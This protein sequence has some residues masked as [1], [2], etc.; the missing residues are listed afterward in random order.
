MSTYFQYILYTAMFSEYKYREYS[1]Y[2][3]YSKYLA[4]R[5]INV[6]IFKIC[7]NI[8]NIQPI[9]VKKLSIYSL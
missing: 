6:K 4:V 3:Q 1:E 7:L 9:N 8:F 5:L 2:F